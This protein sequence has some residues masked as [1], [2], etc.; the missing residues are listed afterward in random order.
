[1]TSEIFSDMNDM[2]F[3]SLESCQNRTNLEFVSLQR[4][5]HFQ[6]GDKLTVILNLRHV[7]CRGHVRN[8][9]AGVPNSEIIRKIWKTSLLVYFYLAVLTWAMRISGKIL[10]NM[11]EIAPQPQRSNTE[12]DP[13]PTLDR[14]LNWNRDCGWTLVFQWWRWFS[15]RAGIQDCVQSI[16][17]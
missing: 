7:N 11:N 6:T 5:T 4:R 12:V 13:S 1:M 15:Y 8:L 3:F 16:K 14:K 10:S 9:H 17:R 2:V